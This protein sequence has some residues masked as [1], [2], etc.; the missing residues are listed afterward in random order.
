MSVENIAARRVE[1]DWRS[2]IVEHLREELRQRLDTCSSIG[3][4]VHVTP[5]EAAYLQHLMEQ[6]KK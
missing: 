5:A 1:T 3:S 4:N 2:E 6:E